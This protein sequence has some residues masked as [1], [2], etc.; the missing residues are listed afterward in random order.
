[1]GRHK[2]R[3]EFVEKHIRISKK[4]NDYIEGEISKNQRTYNQNLIELLE[5]GLKKGSNKAKETLMRI[6]AKC[7]RALVHMFL[8]SRS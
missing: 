8:R 6:N 2:K 4:L 3:E 7:A 1:M 5:I